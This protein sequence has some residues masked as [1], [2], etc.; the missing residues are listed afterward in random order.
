MNKS[1]KWPPQQQYGEELTQPCFMSCMAAGHSTVSIHFGCQRSSVTLFTTCPLAKS[2]QVG[3]GNRELKIN[4]RWPK[5]SQ[6]WISKVA[7]A[8]CQISWKLRKKPYK[9]AFCRFKQVK[10]REPM[11]TKTSSLAPLGSTSIHA[12][13]PFLRTEIWTPSDRWNPL[14]SMQMRTPRF[15][16]ASVQ[17]GEGSISLGKKIK[18]PEIWTVVCILKK[19]NHASMYQ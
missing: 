13:P 17:I 2:D 9:S 3:Q 15:T 19:K 11:A 6:T 8:V 5:Q 4:F 14:Q 18:T 10:Y 12:P 7:V 1:R 16:A